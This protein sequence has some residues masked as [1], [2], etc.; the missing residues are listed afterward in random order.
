MAQH[1]HPECPMQGEKLYGALVNNV[2]HLTI[3]FMLHEYK[4][5]HKNIEI[6]TF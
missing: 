4:M 2:N 5:K 1:H 3:S 6:W